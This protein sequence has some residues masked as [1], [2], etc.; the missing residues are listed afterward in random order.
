MTEHTL[1]NHH[2]LFAI[3]GAILEAGLQQIRIRIA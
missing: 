2:G 3:L 1:K